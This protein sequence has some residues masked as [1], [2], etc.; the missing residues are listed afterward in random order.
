MTL[1]P[2]AVLSDVHG[3]RRA[4]EAVLAD[5]DRRGICRLVH[6]GDCLYGP[7][8]PAGTARILMERQIPGVR[9]NQDRA[10]VASD[11]PAVPGFDQVRAALDPGQLDWLA[12][13]PRV[14]LVDRMLLV[15]GTPTDDTDTLL[16]AVEPAGARR[17]TAIELHQLLLDTLADHEGVLGTDARAGTL[18]PLILCGHDHVPAM[19]QA[20]NGGPATLV[21]DPGS[22]G[23]PAYNATAPHPHVMEAGTPHARYAVISGPAEAPTVEHVSVAYDWDAAADE[24]GRNGRPDWAEWLSS[25]RARLPAV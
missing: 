7:L 18:P 15:H 12:A 6:L 8:D 10:V 9:G 25:G 20:A 22:V 24:A 1:E 16:W 19:A 2:T 13:L 17:R 5:I 14:L 21:V 23:L 11:Q 3:N 4:L